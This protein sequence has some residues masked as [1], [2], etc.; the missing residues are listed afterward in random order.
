MQETSL[1]IYP[2]KK[3]KKRENITETDITWIL[4]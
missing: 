1:E 2:K 3:K 4:I